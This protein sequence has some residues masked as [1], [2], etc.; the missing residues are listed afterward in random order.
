MNNKNTPTHDK[1]IS[2]YL[3]GA[4]QQNIVD[5]VGIDRRKIVDIIFEYELERQTKRTIDNT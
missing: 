4:T 5:V 3:S 2:M 1:I